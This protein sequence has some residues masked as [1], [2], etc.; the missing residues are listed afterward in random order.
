LFTYSVCMFHLFAP[1]CLHVL[2]AYSICMFCLHVLFATSICMFCLQHLVCMFRLHIPFAHSICTLCLHAPLARSICT[3]RLNAPF[4]LHIY[5]HFI[6]TLCLYGPFARFVYT[7]RLRILF[8]HS[9]CKSRSRY[10][11]VTFR[12]HVFR[13]ATRLAPSVCGGGYL[14]KAPSA[15]LKCFKSRNSTPHNQPIPPPNPPA[16]S[17]RPIPNNMKNQTVKT[18]ADT[19]QTPESSSHLSDDKF[20]SYFHLSHRRGKTA[21][22]NFGRWIQHHSCDAGFPTNPS[23]RYVLW[24]SILARFAAADAR[25]TLEPGVDETVRRR[26]RETISVRRRTPLIFSPSYFRRETP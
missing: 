8:A 1:F 17:P 3:F 19:N 20:T 15:H 6:C 5:A 23:E 14:Y 2:F 18:I 7:F 9:V 4:R 26:A 22:F 25:N 24:E 10:L 11:R 21:N 13:F 16:Q 12:L